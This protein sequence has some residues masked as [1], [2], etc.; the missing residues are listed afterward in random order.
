MGWTRRGPRGPLAPCNL[1]Y[2][3][4][5]ENPQQQHEIEKIWRCD[6]SRPMLPPPGGPMPDSTLIP[7]VARY[8]ERQATH[9]L[10]DLHPAR[11]L[12]TDSPRT[13]ARFAVNHPDV[14]LATLAGIPR[15]YI[16]RSTSCI[17]T[18]TRSGMA[19]K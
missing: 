3:R 14:K 11:D 18:C 4:S 6:R 2:E 7:G 9:P 13:L 12:S 1:L 16:C 15:R 17:N 10:L 8:D 5:A 19:P